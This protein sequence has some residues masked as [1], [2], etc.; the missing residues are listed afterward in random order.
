[1]FRFFSVEFPASSQS[2]LPPPSSNNRDRIKY[3]V[4]D[5]RIIIVTNKATRRPPIN[6]AKIKN[7]KMATKSSQKALARTHRCFLFMF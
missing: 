7:A 4:V 5:A 2:F 3:Y 6:V 1:M